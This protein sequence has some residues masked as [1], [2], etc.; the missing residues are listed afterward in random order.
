MKRD[1]KKII[2]QMTLEEKAG[3]CSGL[4]F[5]HLKSVERLG[6]PEVMVSDGPHGL[7]KQ[8]DK[9]DHLGMNGQY[10]S[11]LLPSCCFKCLLF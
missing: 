5:W 6:I 2:S 9:G 7:R 10:Q 3:M 4:D 11:S 1:L 8:D